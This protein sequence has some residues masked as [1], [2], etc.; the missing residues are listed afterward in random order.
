MVPAEQRPNNAEIPAEGCW[1]GEH[2]RALD[3]LAIE[4]Y[5]IP[6]LL[7]MEHASI[8]IAL[9]CIEQLPPGDR[10]VE[11]V[12]GPGNNG[13]DGI[14]IARHLHNVGIEVEVW[15]LVSPDLPSQGSD[16]DAQIA[17]A[18][19]LGISILDCSETLPRSERVA[20]L[21]VDAIFGTGLKRPPRGIFRKAIEDLNQQSAPVLAVDLP[22]GLDSDSG[23]PLDLAVEAEITVAL[24]LPKR[25]FLADGAAPF[26]GALYC[27]PIG[28]SGNLLPAGVPAFPPLPHR[29]RRVGGDFEIAPASVQ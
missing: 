26:T 4:Q 14:A 19:R 1:S 9:Q 15:D 21:R 20:D 16:R 6:S 8:G 22:S 5:E 25:G 28:V 2:S 7:L 11:I 13:G 29:V 24:G 10:F 12:C 3:R 27:V 17:I 18:R 23:L